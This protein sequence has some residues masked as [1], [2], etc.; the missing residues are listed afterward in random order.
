[1]KHSICLR[2]RNGIRK[3]ANTRLRADSGEGELVE[4]GLSSLLLLFCLLSNLW[5]HS[6]G[7]LSTTAKRIPAFVSPPVLPPFPASRM[8]RKVTFSCSHTR[9]FA[10]EQEYFGWLDLTGLHKYVVLAL[11]SRL[12]RTIRIGKRDCPL[13]F[14]SKAPSRPLGFLPFQN[15]CGCYTR[16]CVLHRVFV[17]RIRRGA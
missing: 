11:R 14:N 9:I 7:D 10:A 8:A 12:E 4:T 6:S 15:C 5:S 13:S 1:M 17:S 3:P 16:F 2:H